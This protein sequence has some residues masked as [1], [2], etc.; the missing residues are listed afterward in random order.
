MNKGVKF[1]VSFAAG[2]LL[3]DVFI[4]LIPEM[5]V[6]GNL[7]FNVSISI[8]VTIV[9]FFILEKYL[10]WHHHH[11]GDAAEHALHPFVFT[12]LAGDAVH[13]IVDGMIIGAA[14]LVSIEVGIAT[15]IAVILH[16]IPQE[17]GDFGVLVYG[18]LSRAKALFYN[19]ISA[20]SALIGTI[21]VLALGPTEE[22]VS[23]FLAMG[24]G[25]F[26]Y[27]A[28]SDLIPAIHREKEKVFSQF[29][30]FILG[31]VVMFLLLYLE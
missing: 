7:N 11:E 3:G 20:L 24:I 18:G 22:L 10:H 1:L 17:I 19:F 30:S 5:A 4:H 9:G 14:Y 28:S 27:I 23:V 26:I 25:S 31:I 16:E 15:T 13:N 29:V 21:L 12:N 6:E 8:L 2:A